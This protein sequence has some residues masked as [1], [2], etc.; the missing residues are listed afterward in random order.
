VERRQVEQ[1]ERVVKRAAATYSDEA[2]MQFSAVVKRSREDAARRLS[3]ELERAVEVFARQAGVRARRAPGACRRRWCA[4]VSSTG[5][6][7]PTAA[8]EQ[9]RDERLAAVDGRIAELEATS[10]AGSTSWPPTPIDRAWGDRG[11]PAG[12]S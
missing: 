11:A 7:T 12:F 8:L 3:R 6:Q 1:L 4:S 9:R 10:A 5:S 2:A